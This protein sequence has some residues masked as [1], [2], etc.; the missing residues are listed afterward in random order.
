MPKYNQELAA[1]VPSLAAKRILVIGDVMLDHYVWGEVDRISPE[2]PVPVVHVQRETE[3][4]GGAANVA[5]NVTAL[6]G[7]ATLVGI[8]GEDSRG[9]TL[10]D[11]C[12][13]E[14]IQTHFARDDRPTTSK[15]RFISQNQQLLRAD[16]EEGAPATAETADRLCEILRD[17][18][19]Q[20]DLVVISD[21]AKGT[22]TQP[23]TDL[24]RESGTR[25]VVDPKPSQKHLYRGFHLMTPNAKEAAALTDRPRPVFPPKAEAEEILRETCENVLITCGA[26]GMYICPGE[27]EAE[28]IPSRARQVYEV[29]G[30]GDTVVA[31][32]ALA[33]AAGLDLHQAAVMAN[34]AAGLVVGKVGTATISPEELQADLLAHED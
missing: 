17:E 24:L 23:V 34:H 22:I 12:G 5:R 32:A 27:G 13:V 4:P 33:L 26:E 20:A 29:S 16:W 25:V 8:I 28:S 9:E 2:A 15:V 1:A 30:A 18:L 3:L 6:G 21:Y 7:A 11:L 14:D 10:Q 31:V 19:P